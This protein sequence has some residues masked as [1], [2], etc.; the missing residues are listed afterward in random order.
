[1]HFSECSSS[2]NPEEST[3]AMREM[4]GPQAVARAIDQ[5]IT[6]CWMMLPEKKKT[7][8]AVEAEIRRIVDRSLSNL[9]E[10]ASA[11]GIPAEE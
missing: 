11:F 5:A 6:T 4:F 2:D 1:M 10:D 9:R 7:V 3:K 8:A